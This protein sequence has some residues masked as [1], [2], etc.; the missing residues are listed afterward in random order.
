MDKQE[1]EQ[2]LVTLAKDKHISPAEV[3]REMELT[4][5]SAQASKDPAIQARW[6]MIPHKG[7]K[8]TL[9]ELL[10]YVAGVLRR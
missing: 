8:V 10:E 9:E 5:A 6:K 1:L 4:L 7:E 3:R 2:I